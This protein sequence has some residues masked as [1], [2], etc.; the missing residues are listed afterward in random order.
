MTMVAFDE[1]YTEILNFKE[2]QFVDGMTLEI[3]PVGKY[4]SRRS[5]L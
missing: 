4:P 1:I 2:S 5:I 3:I